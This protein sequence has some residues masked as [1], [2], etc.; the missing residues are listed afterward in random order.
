MNDSEKLMYELLFAINTRNQIASNMLTIDEMHE[1]VLALIEREHWNN[2]QIAE[3]TRFARQTVAK[4]AR[5]GGKE[6][7]RVGGGKLNRACLDILYQL[8]STWATDESAS[9][10]LL[11]AAI[12]TG[13]GTRLISRLTGVTI[14]RVLYAQR[15]MKEEK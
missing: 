7:K 14:G 4:I 13:T 3:I 10:P 2:A 8:A 15:N 12:S 1:K 5:N 6:P 11:Q 9:V